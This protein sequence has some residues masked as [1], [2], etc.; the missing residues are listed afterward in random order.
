MVL[1]GAVTTR[2]YGDFKWDGAKAHANFLKHD[3][4]FEESLMAFADPLAIDAPDRYRLGRFVLIGH[5]AR[6]RVL[7][8]VYEE[9]RNG[10]RLI[11]ARKASPSKGENMKRDSTHRRLIPPEDALE[12]Y[13]WARP[14]GGGTPIASR[15]APTPSSSPRSYGGTSQRRMP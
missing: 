9:R 13:D 7:F 15:K 2:R 14:P 6:G 1:F 5:S 4:S 11:S 3:V 12:R 8:V 10:I